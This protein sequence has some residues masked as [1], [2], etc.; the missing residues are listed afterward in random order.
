MNTKFL[1][2]EC[3]KQIKRIRLSEVYYLQYQD[4]HICF[5]LTDNK[6]ELHCQLLKTLEEQLPDYFVR[7]NRN[8]IINLNYLTVYFKTT[9]KVVMTNGQEFDVSRRNVAR[10]I[11]KLQ[12]VC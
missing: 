7:I 3:Q 9:P 11:K 1:L 6:K 10:L 4:G 5:Y 2:L 8:V 12:Q